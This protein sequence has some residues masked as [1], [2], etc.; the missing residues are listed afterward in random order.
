M[1]SSKN[2]RRRIIPS[3]FNDDQLVVPAALRP[4][5][6]T[7]WSRVSWTQACRAK[8]R[9]LTESWP[10]RPTRRTCRSE[11]SL[12]LLSGARVCPLTQHRPELGFTSVTAAVFSVFSSVSSFWGFRVESNAGFVPPHWDGRDA[13][14]VSLTRV[15]GT[16]IINKAAMWSFASGRLLEGEAPKLSIN[17]QTGAEKYHI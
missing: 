11:I 2:A 3:G 9:C 5:P 16:E 8:M 4:P 17:R 1:S 6:Q 13:V 15:S 10:H 12:Q 7:R 14:S